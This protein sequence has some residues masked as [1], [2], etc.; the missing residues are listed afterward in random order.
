MSG[1]MRVRR[2]RVGCSV[3]TGKREFKRIGMDGWMPWWQGQYDCC[4]GW[5]ISRQPLGRRRPKQAGRPG[6]IAIRGLEL[7]SQ[8]PL[9]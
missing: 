6:S 4:F 5:E 3:S 1:C 7:R 2:R 8:P 9:P